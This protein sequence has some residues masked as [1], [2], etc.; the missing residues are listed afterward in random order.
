MRQCVALNA[1]VMRTSTDNRSD[2]GTHRFIVVI[3]HRCCEA[4][5]EPNRIRVNCWHYM[6]RN[7]NANNYQTMTYYDIK[8]DTSQF[9]TAPMGRK[10]LFARKLATCIFV[11]AIVPAQHG[12]CTECCIIVTHRGDC[13]RGYCT[14]LAYTMG[15]KQ[16]QRLGK[17]Y[18]YIAIL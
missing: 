6:I 10:E 5:R 16:H 1:S 13:I 18:L 9:G 4:C 7:I 8:F 3:M 11:T 12:D 14:I 15:A 17:L 2:F